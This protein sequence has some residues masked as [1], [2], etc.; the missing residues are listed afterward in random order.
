MSHVVRMCRHRLYFSPSI[1]SLDALE[2]SRTKRTEEGLQLAIAELPLEYA[3]KNMGPSFSTLANTKGYY[4][5]LHFSLFP[6]KLGWVL[7]LV[8]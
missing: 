3:L 4:I 6:F 1:A 7:L 8:E 5:Q 2:I